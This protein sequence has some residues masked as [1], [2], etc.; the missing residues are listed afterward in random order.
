MPDLSRY[1]DDTWNRR[2]REWQAEFRLSTRPAIGAMEAMGCPERHRY[3]ARAVAEGTFDTNATILLHYNRP[4]LA[5]EKPCCLWAAL[6][7]LTCENEG[8]REAH[9]GSPG[10][11]NCLGCTCLRRGVL[12]PGWQPLMGAPAWVWTDGPTSPE[13]SLVAPAENS[14]AATAGSTRDGGSG[15]GNPERTEGTDTRTTSGDGKPAADAGTPDERKAQESSP[16]SQTNDSDGVSE[17]TGTEETG[18][19]GGD[20]NTHGS[21]LTK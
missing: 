1:G 8:D 13:V 19:E 9:D 5:T 14:A 21:S 15:E 2:I 3:R 16:D 7:G 17:G 4:G 6:F 10:C 11:P 12:N 20:G 18:M